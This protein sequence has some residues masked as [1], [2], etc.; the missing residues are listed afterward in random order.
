MRETKINR[1]NTPTMS[2]RAIHS[3]TTTHTGRAE[4]QLPLIALLREM[5]VGTSEKR[6]LEEKAPYVEDVVE[7]FLTKFKEVHDQIVSLGLGDVQLDIVTNASFA[8][9]V[10]RDEQLDAAKRDVADILARSEKYTRDRKEGACARMS[11]DQK[12]EYEVKRREARAT[13]DEYKERAKKNQPLSDDLLGLLRQMQKSYDSKIWPYLHKAFH[14]SALLWS[15][16][17]DKS[18]CDYFDFDFH[19]Y[20]YTNT[21]FR[22]RGLWLND[23]VFQRRI[24]ALIGC[25]GYRASTSQVWGTRLTFP[26]D[27]NNSHRAL[28]SLE[29]ALALQVAKHFV[30][31]QF[32]GRRLA[33]EPKPGVV[34][35]L[36]GWDLPLYDAATRI[37][38]PGPFHEVLKKLETE[39]GSSVPFV[40]EQIRRLLAWGHSRML[41]IV[42]NSCEVGAR[43]QVAR[44]PCIEFGVGGQLC[45]T[46]NAVLDLIT[47][48][49]AVFRD[50]LYPEQLDLTLSRHNPDVNEAR[51][52]RL[53][54]FH[55]SKTHQVAVAA[56]GQHARVLIKKSSNAIAVVDPWKTESLVQVP[57]VLTSVFTEPLEW[58]ERE[59]EQ[60][61]ESSCALLA[62]SRAVMV[63]WAI[64]QELD[65]RAAAQSSM[66]SLTHFGPLAL[67]LVRSA[68]RIVVTRQGAWPGRELF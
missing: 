14:K 7:F 26:L 40:S 39:A 44:R 12:E 20:P 47:K 52:A 16:S 1:I 42:I 50:K 67:T 27:G 33:S 64:E 59:P 4:A 55:A 22:M 41:A 29:V 68:H 60:G 2:T 24:I 5:T 6:H 23:L 51:R 34:S 18:I 10:T 57:T 15:P 46:I 48:G 25:V 53:A 11:L 45:A 49:A 66:T 13:I 58:I 8:E 32:H 43:G 3:P 28:L 19:V 63:A 36:F 17:Y 54:K 31:L 61:G 30:R 9:I 38:I 56:W 21:E 65:F 37:R 35:N 62:T